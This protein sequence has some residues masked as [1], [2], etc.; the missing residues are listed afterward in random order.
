MQAG[1]SVTRALP[2]SQV[3]STSIG[4]INVS[5]CLEHALSQGARPTLHRRLIRWRLADNCTIDAPA[6]VVGTSEFEDGVIQGRH[7]FSQ[8]LQR[9]FAFQARSKPLGDVFR[10]VVGLRVETQNV[11]TQLL[12]PC[13]HRLRIDHYFSTQSEPWRW[14]QHRWG[15]SVGHRHSRVKLVHPVSAPTPTARN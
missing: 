11:A 12:H 10:Q 1:C 9:I 6:P 14:V 15:W 3:S 7:L 4:V 8:I 2:G 5:L 13:Y